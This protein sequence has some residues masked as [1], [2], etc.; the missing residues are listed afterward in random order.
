MVHSIEQFTLEKLTVILQPSI[1]MSRFIMNL[2]QLDRG[3]NVTIAVTTSKLSQVSDLDFGQ[4]TSIMGNMG[5][6]L[7]DGLDEDDYIGD[8][9]L[10]TPVDELGVDKDVSASDFQTGD[11][12]VALDSDL[13][14]QNSDVQP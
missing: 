10:D 9:C 4:A 6:E 1:L 7:D 14:P 3:T 5:A 11:S 13:G 8:E 12:V 2:R